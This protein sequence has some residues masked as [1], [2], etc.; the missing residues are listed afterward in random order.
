VSDETQ[1]IHE[2]WVIRKTWTIIVVILTTFQTNSEF[3]STLYQKLNHVPYLQSFRLYS[4][5]LKGI[6][7]SSDLIFY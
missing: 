6:N 3:A 2:I 7:L 5:K 1:Q 4:T